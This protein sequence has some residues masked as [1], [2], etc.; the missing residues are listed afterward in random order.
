MLHTKNQCF[1]VVLILHHIFFFNLTT[2]LISHLFCQ[3]GDDGVRVGVPHELEE[4]LV[5]GLVEQHLTVTLRVLAAHVVDG[6][7]S[8][9]LNTLLLTIYIHPC[10]T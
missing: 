2:P 6:P 4:N 10:L 5:A 7:H 3:V 9:Q 8:P 1:I